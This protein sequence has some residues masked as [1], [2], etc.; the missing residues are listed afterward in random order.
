MTYLKHNWCVLV[1]FVFSCTSDYTA[2]YDYFPDSAFEKLEIRFVEEANLSDLVDEIRYIPLKTDSTNLIGVVNTIRSANDLFYILDK[3]T[4]SILCFD[5]L[6]SFQFA[7]RNSGD[8]PQEYRH[9]VDFEVQDDHSVILADPVRSVQVYNPD[10]T[11]RFAKGI[12]LN[13]WD[14][15]LYDS[16][17]AVLAPD[18]FSVPKKSDGTPYEGTLFMMSP[19]LDTVYNAYFPY[20]MFDNASEANLFSGFDGRLTYAR[21]YL[22]RFY[23]IGGRG[24]LR[25]RYLVDF[26]GLNVPMGMLETPD[27]PVTLSKLEQLFFEGKAASRLNNVYETKNFFTFQFFQ[28][29]SQNEEDIPWLAIHNKQQQK[30]IAVKSIVND[31]DGGSFGFPKAIQG[32][33][34]IGIVFPEKLLERKDDISGPLKEIADSLTLEDNPVLMIYRLKDTISL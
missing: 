5:S 25:P 19:E 30:T 14:F 20:N 18:D 23:F 26:G 7:I 12:D 27:D 16:L 21:T 6:G 17:I 2:P 9:I 24:D 33:Y 10:G 29:D 32:E 31:L 28:W 15:E 11:F 22:Q 1:L 34:L 13:I 3:Q 4:G 8:G